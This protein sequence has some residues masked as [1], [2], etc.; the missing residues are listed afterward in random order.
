MSIA[1]FNTPLRPIKFPI[2]PHTIVR[3]IVSQVIIFEKNIVFI[4]LKIDFVFANSAEPEEMSHYHL[5]LH[6]LPKYQFRGFWS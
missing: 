3:S 2:K 5:G 1:I 6:C 4:S